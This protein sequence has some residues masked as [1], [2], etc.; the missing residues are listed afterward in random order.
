MSN[1]LLTKRFFSPCSVSMKVLGHSK[2]RRKILKKFGYFFNPNTLESWN[3]RW[4]QNNS[5]KLSHF[6][7]FQKLCAS[8]IQINMVNTSARNDFC[9]ADEYKVEELNNKYK[10]GYRIDIDFIRKNKPKKTHAGGE[11]F[12]LISKEK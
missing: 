11:Y 4:C 10:Q 2:L 6:L 12:K 8:A 3:C 7:Y 9:S 1:N 5:Q